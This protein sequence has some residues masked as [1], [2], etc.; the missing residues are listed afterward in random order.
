MALCFL[1]MVTA[2]VL[3]HQGFAEEPMAQPFVESKD[4]K[5]ENRPTCHPERK[6]SEFAHSFL[7][8]R[9]E[10]GHRAA[11]ENKASPVTPVALGGGTVRRLG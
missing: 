11:S 3:S 6:W 7:A 9:C 1:P 5:S 4:I 10:S 8:V 2:V